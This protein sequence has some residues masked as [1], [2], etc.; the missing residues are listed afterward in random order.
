VKLPHGLVHER[1]MT[2]SAT[3]AGRRGALYPSHSATAPSGIV[4]AAQAP[5]PARAPGSKRRR[6]T[7]GTRIFLPPARPVEWNNQLSRCSI[8]PPSPAASRVA[9]AKIAQATHVPARC[10]IRK[11]A[12]IARRCC[13]ESYHAPS[14][15][16]CRSCAP[17]LTLPVVEIALYRCSLTVSPST[18]RDLWRMSTA[19]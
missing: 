10:L 9:A 12:P 5:A 3:I 14:P 16:T 11:V 19:R 15:V 18:W 2:Q 6:K 8:H 1:R 17:R 4:P 7:L 13:G